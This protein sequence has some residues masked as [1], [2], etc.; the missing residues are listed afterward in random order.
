MQKFEEAFKI[1]HIKTTSFHP[2]SNGALERTHA[3]IK[4]LIRTCTTD[5]QNEWDEVINLI[6]LGYNTSVH[7]G[8]GHIPFE[9]TFG[10][11]ANMPSAISATSTLSREELFKLWKKRHESYLESAKKIISR[12]KARYKR[13]QDRKIRLQCLFNEGDR[14]LIHND[15]KR[16]KLDS[17]WIGPAIITKVINPYYI[18]KFPNQVKEYKVHENRLKLYKSK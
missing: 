15:P 3:T 12:N 1:K 6:C 14:V 5:R 4:D 7:E 2:Q 17:E 18:C 11:K 13:D 8:T 10:H 16:N 9:L